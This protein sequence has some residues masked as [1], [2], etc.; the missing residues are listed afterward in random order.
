MLIEKSRS[1]PGILCSLCKHFNER[2]GLLLKIE[3]KLCQIEFLL[4]NN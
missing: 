1:F 3:A 4:G 2:S